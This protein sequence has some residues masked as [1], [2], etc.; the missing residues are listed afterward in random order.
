MMPT[1]NTGEIS[2]IHHQLAGQIAGLFAA[3]PQVEAVALAGSRGGG[4]GST[5]PTSDIDLYVYTHGDIPLAERRTIL[6]RS[7]GATWASLDMTYWGLGDEWINAP[8]GIE[9]DLIYF[10]AAWMEDQ[11][12]R[13]VER[14]QAS[15]GYT[16]CFW[17]TVRNSIIY[18]DPQGW[19]AA[20][21]QR[22]QIEYPETLRQNIV[23]L[24]YPV[25][26]S[27][28]PAFG[29]QIEKAAKRGDLVSINH[30]TAALLASYFDIL[31]AVNRQLH[32]GEKRLVELACKRCPILPANMEAD[33]ASILLLTAEDIVDLPTRLTRLLDHLDQ[34]LE[35]A[36]FDL[37]PPA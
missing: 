31:F 10:E 7:G 19:F 29:N 26:R 24:N 16:T 32:P 15:L 5:D 37:K 23:A 11:I 6:E 21:Q 8:T 17:Y 12:A 9:V 1:Q 3:L 30:R 33:L 14:Q 13:V 35:H 22:C 27:I 18:A 2:S 36:G 34:M 25:L 20:L 4:A 28:I